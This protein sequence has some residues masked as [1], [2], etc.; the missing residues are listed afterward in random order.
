MKGYDPVE[1]YLGLEM[2]DEA[3]SELDGMSDVKKKTERHGELLLAAQM[4]SEKWSE[5][6]ETANL[7]C[8]RNVTE[9]SYF[10][11]AAFCLHEVGKTKM[12]LERLLSGPPELRSQALYHYNMA[13]YYSVLGDKHVAQES[14]SKAFDLDAALKKVAAKDEDLKGVDF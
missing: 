11:H 13:C 7:L 6:V 2:A 12:A 14:L 4:M 9:C 10:I 5:A 3:L 8:E 1:G